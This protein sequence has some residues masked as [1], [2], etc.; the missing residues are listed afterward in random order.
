MGLMG[1][2]IAYAVIAFF[3]T[4]GFLTAA[5][6]LAWLFRD[7]GEEAASECKCGRGRLNMTAWTGVDASETRNPGKPKRPRL[8][9]RFESCRGLY[10]AAW[11]SGSSPGSYPGGRAFKSRRRYSRYGDEKPE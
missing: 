10:I 6:V 4:I 5:V 9:R 8:Q 7:N 2:T 1:E 11:S 3:A